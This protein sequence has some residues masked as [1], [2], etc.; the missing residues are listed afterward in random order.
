MLALMDLLRDW[1]SGDIE[2]QIEDVHGGDND[3]ILFHG[4]VSKAFQKFKKLEDKGIAYELY[5]YMEIDPSNGV[6]YIQ[7]AEM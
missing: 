5:T 1:L 7:V 2:C 4:T 6:L 3:Y